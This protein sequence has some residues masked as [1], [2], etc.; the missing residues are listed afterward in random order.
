MNNY[1]KHTPI[2]YSEVAKT[3][4]TNFFRRL[5]LMDLILRFVHWSSS[6]Q[7]H[8]A[9]SQKLQ[10]L[11]ASLKGDAAKLLASL[12]INDANYPVALKMLRDRYQNNHMILRAHVH[13]ISTQKQLTNETAKEL[14]QL[15]ETVE[16]HR[17]AL[18][19][20][21][22]PVDQQDIFLVYLVTEKLPAD[23]TKFWELSTPGTDPQT[24]NDLK[25]FLEARCLALEAST[26]SAPTISSQ[27]RFT[28]R[29]NNNNQQSHS[30][31][32][33]YNTNTKT[34]EI[35][36]ECCNGTHKLHLCP[37]FKQFSVPN[38]AEFVKR[39]K[40][41]FTCLRAGHR[42]QECRGSTCKNYYLK[43][44]TLL[45]LQTPRQARSVNSTVADKNRHNE[46]KKK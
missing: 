16:E 2:R 42:Q 4:S 36:C 32:R 26:L 7:R 9:E 24:Y 34:N 35:N 10:Y 11:E 43:H 5:S 41:C 46:S 40:L 27:H 17:L 18:E 45:H 29:Q 13:A 14:H 20:M 31:Q 38:R 15:V 39:K 37:K 22:Q 33:N 1:K 23:T 30:S 12:T 6:Q 28:T 19:N 44:H 21:G 3:G 25:K 8:P